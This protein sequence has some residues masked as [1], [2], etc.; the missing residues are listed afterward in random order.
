MV[1]LSRILALSAEKVRGF[2]G[3]KCLDP[4]R[5]LLSELYDATKRFFFVNHGRS[6]QKVASLK[7]QST[8]VGVDRAGCG[9]MVKS[10]G[11]PQDGQNIC[12]FSVVGH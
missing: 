4:L 6:Y 5:V 10:E 9:E 2:G 1:T 3:G 12:E 8:A 7:S 11:N